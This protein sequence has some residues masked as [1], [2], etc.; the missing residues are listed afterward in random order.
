MEIEI[1]YKGKKEKVVLKS[2]S[3][4][5]NNECVRVGMTVK[6]DGK[7][8]LDFVLQQ[9]HKLVKSIVSAPF[10]VTLENLRALP[11]KD[12]D[13]LFNAMM[14]LNQVESGVAK[15]SSPPLEVKE[16]SVEK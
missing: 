7:T 5:E 12:G 16:T 15:N 9:E 6:P 2:L 1:D 8:N 11:A 13:K 3:W 4:G 10:E 14:K